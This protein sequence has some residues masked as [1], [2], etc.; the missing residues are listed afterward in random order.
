[1]TLIPN[2]TD[3]SSSDDRFS[4]IVPSAKRALS[5]LKTLATD[6]RDIIALADSLQ[7]FDGLTAALAEKRAALSAVEMACKAKETELGDILD[8]LVATGAELAVRENE[9]AAV[10]AEMADKTAALARTRA[11]IADIIERAG[12]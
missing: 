8:Q 10:N 11:G 12:L 5:R 7:Q 1:M 9:L 2:A 6:L 3:T 4:A